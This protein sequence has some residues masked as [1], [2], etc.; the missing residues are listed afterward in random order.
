MVRS[1]LR[2]ESASGVGGRW[3]AV[4]AFEQRWRLGRGSLPAQNLMIIYID[5]AIYQ[6]L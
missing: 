2:S 4:P 5:K 3:S 6:V 1:R